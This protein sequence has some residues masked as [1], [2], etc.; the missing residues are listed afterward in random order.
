V[1]STARFRTIQGAVN[2]ARAGD[3]IRIAPGTYREQVNVTKDRLKF[4]AANSRNK[5]IIT[6]TNRL[7]GWRHTGGNLWVANLTGSNSNA[8]QNRATLRVF[9]NGRPQHEGKLKNNADLL[10]SDTWNRFERGTRNTITDNNPSRR[11]NSSLVGAQVEVRVNKFRLESRRITAVTNG[12]RTLRVDKNFSIVPKSNNPYRI[13]DAKSLVDAPEEW[14]FNEGQNK[15]YLKV[16]PNQNPNTATVEVT[17]RED[18]F[19]INRKNGLLF[20]DLSLRGG[21]FK[22]SGTNDS[23]FDGLTIRAADRAS[24]PEFASDQRARGFLLKGNRNRVINSS[25]ALA[26]NWNIQVSGTENRIAN[27][28]F[29]NNQLGGGGGSILVQAGSQRTSIQRNTFLKSG[30]SAITGRGFFQTVIENNR[31]S[32]PA[33]TTEDTGSIYFWNTNVGNTVIR[34]N[35]FTDAKGDFVAGIYI[36]NSVRNIHIHNNTVTNSNRGLYLNTGVIRARVYDNTFANGIDS[37]G[38]TTGTGSVNGKREY[39]EVSI[40]NNRTPFIG[41]NFTS[42]AVRVRPRISGNSNSR[43]G[44]GSFSSGSRGRIT[45]GQTSFNFNG[46]TYSF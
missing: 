4:V 22:I 5:P 17:R 33:Q 27:N 42:S 28:H 15:L 46:S 29:N 3:T 32:S 25:F 26:Y 6:T 7:T 18:I 39:R 34:N 2:N 12:G 30:R 19:V 44:A 9:Y 23:V 1:G 43:P 35:S 16:R 20:K 41:V 13:L 40:T 37:G 38:I 45:P 14:Y 11:F 36:D 10:N 24:G 8:F 21:D 31:F